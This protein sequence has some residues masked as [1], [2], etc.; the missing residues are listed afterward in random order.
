MSESQSSVEKIIVAV[1]GIGEQIRCETIQ[2]VANQFCKYYHA[3]AGF[4]LGRMNAK[5]VPLPGASG[6]RGAFM[7][8]SPPDPRWS[9]PGRGRT[10]RSG[11]SF[12]R[13]RLS[14]TSGGWPPCFSISWWRG[15]IT[16]AVRRS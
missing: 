7:V 4:P 11:R 9:R 6:V 14:C 13:P 10:S 12:W 8:E 15:T 3:S 2:A 16:S 5:L 1:H